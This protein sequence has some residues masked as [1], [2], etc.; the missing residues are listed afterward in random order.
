MSKGILLAAAGLLALGGAAFAADR[1]GLIGSGDGAPGLLAA[2]VRLAPGSAQAQEAP[3]IEVLGAAVD[4]PPT[5]AGPEDTQQRYD[6]QGDA[7]RVIGSLASFDAVTAGVTGPTGPIA[8]SLADQFD[9]R[10]DLTPGSIVEMR[11]TLA[12]DGTR[13]AHEVRSGC[14]ASGVIDCAVENDPQFQLFVDADSFQV[15]GRLESITDDQVRV[16]GPGLVVEISRDAG[17]QIEGGLAAGSPVKVEG[18]VLDDRQLRAL[19]VALRCAEAATATPVATAAASQ[20][21]PVEDCDRG[22]GDRGNLRFEVDDGEVDI[23]RGTVLSATADSITVDSPAGPVNVNTDENTEIDG[24]LASA[25]EVEV[26]GD[27]RS[28]DSVLAS[29]IKVLCPET[30]GRGVDDDG[31]DGDD[32]N[33]RD[34]GGDGD[35]DNNRGGDGDGGGNGGRGDNDDGGGGDDD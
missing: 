31:G 16:L 4:C 32:D 35:D 22:S 20:T 10:G 19:T 9:L 6:E 5:G 2:E 8:A 21:T 33:N 34:D 1:A 7:F 12:N 11:G 28:D 26:Q 14:A 3:P 17:T 27:L 18:T 29:E 24:D 25:V 13:T 15:T 30:R 23:E